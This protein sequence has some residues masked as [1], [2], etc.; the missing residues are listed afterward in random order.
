MTS[1]FSISI[2]M[3]RLF[4]L[5]VT[6]LL[7]SC[8]TLK[9]ENTIWYNVTPAEKDGIKANV[10]TALYFGEDGVVNFN[11]SVKQDTTMIV[12]PCFT[13]FCK[14]TYSGN[15]KKGIKVN[16]EGQSI[17]G[18][19]TKYTG[20]IFSEGMVLISQDSIAKGYKMAENLRLK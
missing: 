8:A 20:I 2:S 9:L 15:L 4:L 11:T 1:P 10:Y 5:C 17:D 7:C 6:A 19:P 16:I 13:E 12:A 3:K 14:Y 18:Y